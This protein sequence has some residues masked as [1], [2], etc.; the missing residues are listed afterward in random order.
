MLKIENKRDVI[1]VAFFVASVITLIA[2]ISLPINNFFIHVDEYFT[3]ALIK[4]PIGDAINLTAGD[5]HPPFYYILLKVVSKFLTMFGISYSSVYTF[6]LVSI[7]P[8]VLL[9]VLSLGKI[10]KDYGWLSAGLFI[11]AV[12][13]MSDLFIHYVTLRMYSWGLLFLLLAFLQVRRIIGKSDK[14]S[15][16][17]LSIF[18]VLGAYTH[19]FVAINCVI[20]YIVLL[21]Y[22]LLNKE[23]NLSRLGEFKKWLISSV[24]G[25]VLYIPWLS[26][27]FSQLNQVHES[28]W[29]VSPGMNDII[30]FLSFTSV[31][32]Y[33]SII[34]KILAIILLI[35]FILISYKLYEKYSKDK[36]HKIN[37][38]RKE[39]K[40]ERLDIKFASIGIGIFLL[41]IILG[42][43]ISLLFK[44]I[45]VVR[46]L[47]PCLA[48]VWLSF[49][50]IIG[51]IKDNRILIPLLI[52]IVILASVSITDNINTVAKHENQEMEDQKLIS[53]INTNDSI[54][55]FYNSI[56]FIM[57]EDHLNNAQTYTIHYES[58]KNSYW[59]SVLNTYK[60]YK[61]IKKSDVDKII[62]E[63]KDSK[64]IYIIKV[65]GTE[66]PDTEYDL[67]KTGKLSYTRDIYKVK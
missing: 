42:V 24:L 55:I 57:F 37:K 63:N 26:V 54:V 62:K 28:Y 33:S 34:F 11:F 14:T 48:I 25:V 16:F 20:I 40:K 66:D 8:Y 29:I 17:L 5:V 23:G 51:K 50:I 10:R 64:K 56:N 59:D 36:S 21:A 31:N 45:I 18:S 41:T 1:G 19:Y 13:V 32:E 35:G 22:I 27:L 65:I 58:L 43:L 60:N 53:Q 44:P 47:I 52:I 3:L 67:E 7:I 46:Y 30:N 38:S 6:K 49:S 12:G 4:L 15:W 61:E 2:M 39:V 9:M